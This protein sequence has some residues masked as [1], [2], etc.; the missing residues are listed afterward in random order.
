MPWWHRRTLQDEL[1]RAKEHKRQFALSLENM[2]IRMS[3]LAKAELYQEKLLTPEELVA[4]IDAVSPEDIVR[5]GR[6]L[7]PKRLFLAGGTQRSGGG[8]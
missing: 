4:K 8:V 3:R 5:V 6:R 7:L 1:D 2:A